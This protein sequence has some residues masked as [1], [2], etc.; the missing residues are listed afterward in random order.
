MPET[1]SLRE[2][3]AACSSRCF[4]CCP[5]SLSGRA[6]RTGEDAAFGSAWLHS[7]RSESSGAQA[8]TSLLGVLIGVTGGLL[9]AM[10][11]TLEK[12]RVL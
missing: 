11:A 9:G 5:A 4:C 3:L 8:P 7:A 6:N 1:L 2:T 10:R 12:R